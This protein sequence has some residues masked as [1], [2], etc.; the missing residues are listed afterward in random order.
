[1]LRL[2]TA[3]GHTPGGSSAFGDDAGNKRPHFIEASDVVDEGDIARQPT[4]G[5]YPGIAA[6]AVEQ[7]SRMLLI[8]SQLRPLAPAIHVSERVDVVLRLLQVERHLQAHE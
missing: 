5:S 1:M 3:N 8:G 6:K 2:R 4:H 7:N